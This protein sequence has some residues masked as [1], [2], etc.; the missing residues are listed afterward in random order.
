LMDSVAQTKAYAEADF[1]DSNALF[2]NSFLDRFPGLPG[3]GNLVDLGCGPADICIRL[4]RKLPGWSITGL[5]A[6]PN[7]LRQARQAVAA[8][9]LDNTIRLHLSHLP[10]T[11]LPGA[12]FEAVVSNSLLHHLPSPAILWDTVRALAKPGA[13]VTVMD[14]A[15]P[16]SPQAAQAIVAQYAGDAPDILREDFYNSLLAAYTP[17]EVKRQLS[18]A[19]LD[20][21]GIELSSDRHWM[22]CGRTQ[23]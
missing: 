18:G 23:N 19:G 20:S 14:L 21:L 4:A 17:E 8:A 10:E 15:R 22:V 12:S 3:S 7:M 6:G 16:E 2:V 5:D 1:A 9:K 11:S 13:A